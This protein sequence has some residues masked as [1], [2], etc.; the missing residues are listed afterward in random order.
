MLFSSRSVVARSG[1]LYSPAADEALYFGLRGDGQVVLVDHQ[2]RVDGA[3]G[4]VQQRGP[5]DDVGNGLAG[6]RLAPSPVMTR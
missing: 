4:P 3:E 1:V 5:V 6:G 2:A